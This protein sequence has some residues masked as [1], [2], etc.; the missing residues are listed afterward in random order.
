[1]SA[2]VLFSTFYVFL[3]IFQCYPVD[4]FW[5]RYAGA[6]GKCLNPNVIADATYAHSAISAW[7]DWTLG[8]LPI[9]L[10]W[11]L[12]MNLRTKVSVAL[13]LALGAV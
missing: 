6:V 3:I 9:F 1:M 10:V 11:D 8:I 7:T 5:T 4:Y 12:A 13:I 2:V